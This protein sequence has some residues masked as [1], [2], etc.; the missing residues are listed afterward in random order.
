MYNTSLK[1]I[2]KTVLFQHQADDFWH[3]FQA[4][5]CAVE[6]RR[7]QFFALLAEGKCEAEVLHISQYSVSGARVIID[8]YHQFG[9]D[10][11]KD[12]RHNNQGAP[13]VLTSEEQQQF[14]AQLHQNFEQGIVWDGRK[15]RQWIKETFGKD[16]YLGR[17]YERMHAAGFSPQKPR[18][19]HAQ[20]DLERQE[21]FKKKSS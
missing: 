8:R 19:Q 14:A 11:L 1:K 4:S 16:L 7:A 5:T 21:E 18:P 15:A 9:L 13:T 10:G 2:Y 12:S 3:I 17:V 6:R 20:A